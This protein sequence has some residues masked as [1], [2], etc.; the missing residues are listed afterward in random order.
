VPRSKCDEAVSGVTSLNKPVVNMAASV[1]QRLL[2]LARERKEDFGL[3]LTKYGLERILYRIAQSQHRELFVLKGAL[4]FELWTEQRYRPTRDADFLARGQNSSERFAAIFKEICDV[5]VEDD[6]LLFDAATVTAERITEDA[7]YEG[8]RVKF[9]G[10]LEGARIPIQ[11]DL[12]F[13]DA[14][15]PA[16]IEAELPTLLDL[17]A[18]KLLIYPRESVI[19]EKFEAIVGLGM[20][21][22]RMKDLHDIR[23]LCHEFGFMGDVLSEAI[24]KTFETRGTKLPTGQVLVF[25]SEFFANEDKKKQ[26]AAFCNKNRTYIAEISLE[27]VC[28]EIEQ[29]LMPV[30]EAVNKTGGFQRKWPPGGPWD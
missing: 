30:V 23:S 1:R 4:L 9:V 7:D 26:W 3:M 22:S 13:G 29:F 20:A 6:G 21:N 19:A 28:R 14:I 2:N 15:T 10:Y 27:A 12:G 8:I 17:P 24:A 18:A 25:T 5:R 11:I 16:P